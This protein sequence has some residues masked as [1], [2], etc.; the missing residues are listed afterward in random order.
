[1]HPIRKKR[2]ITITILLSGLLLAIGLVLYALSQNINLYYTP[3]QVDAGQ[4]PK[5]HLFRVGGIVKPG[6]I[7]YA[8]KGLTVEFALTDK[9]HLV[10]VRYH[11]ILPDL[12]R[13]GQGIVT[14]GHLNTKGEFV[15]DQVLAK[16]GATYMPP[17]VA[18]ELKSKT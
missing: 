1:M 10:Y 11:G 17:M 2:L 5:Q 14:Q 12:F 3:S 16:H 8:D 15:A 13:A 4:A 6:S 9:K 18:Q 7:H